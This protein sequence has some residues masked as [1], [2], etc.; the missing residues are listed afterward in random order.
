MAMSQHLGIHGGTQFASRRGAVSA[1]HPLEVAAGLAMLAAG[2]S[3]IDAIVAGAFVACVV[4]PNN[5]SIAGY[6]HLSAYL[7]AEDR[8]LTVDHSPRAPRRATPDMFE[9][10]SDPAPEAHDWP[11]TVGD[12]N[13]VGHLAVAVPGAVRGLY[14]AHREGGRLPW[15]D[16]L[17]P[18]I[19]AAQ[20]GVEVRWNLLLLIAGHLDEIRA[21]PH[22]A[23]LLLPG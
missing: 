8:F 2:G 10:V 6:G 18:A 17:A 13:S 20:D 3:A 22:T 1:G 15:A 16:V 12:R 11:S 19:R 4:E 23:A 5:V 14:E 9:V 7:A 21:R